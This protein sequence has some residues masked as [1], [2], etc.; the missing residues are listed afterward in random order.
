MAQFNRILITGA[1]GALGGMLRH[2]LAGLANTVRL[3]DR[4]TISKAGKNEEIIICDLSDKDAVIDMTRDVDAVVHMGG[5]SREGKFQ[6]I[7]QSNIVGINNLYE[8]CRKNNVGRVVWA[9]SLHSIGFHARTTIMKPD[10]KL[11]PDSNY[12]ASKVY[13]EAI[14][15]YYW[16]KYRIQSVSVRIYSC[17]PKPTDR[18]HLSTW[19]SYPDCAQLFGQCLLAPIVEHTIIYGVSNNKEKMADNTNSGHI[20]FH[21]QDNAEKYREQIEATTDAVAPDDPFLATHGGSF[22]SDGHFED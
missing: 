16:D 18:R 22:V 5:I 6:D 21:P 12:G 19:L 20:G 14:A 4:E 15:Q 2:E 8:G 7:V 3:N 11:R 10:S 17:F 13:G 9:S 1:A